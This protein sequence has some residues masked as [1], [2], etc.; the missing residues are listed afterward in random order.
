MAIEI[1]YNFKPRPYQLDLFQHMEAKLADPNTNEAKALLVWPRQIGKDTTCFAF[2]VRQAASVSGNYFYIFP[3]AKEA[4]KALWDKIMDD[5]SKLLDLLPEQVIARKS[6]QEMFIELSFPILGVNSTIQIIG[7]DLN[8]DAIRGITPQGVVFSEFAFSDFA[9]YK[10]LLAALRRKGCWHIINSTPNG[11]NHFYNIFQGA[12]QSD[13]WYVSFKQGLWKDKDNYV[14]IKPY[15]YFE[16]QV[17]EGLT[18]WEDLEREIGCSFSTGMKGAFYVDQIEEAYNSKR[19]GEFS[20]DDTLKVDTFWDLGVDDSTAVFFRQKINNKIVFIDYYEDSGKDLQHYV[21]VLE[22]KNYNYGTH[23]LPHDANHR[24]L[25]TGNTT[26][27][28]FGDLLKDARISDDIWVLERLPVQ[29]GINAVR[30]RFSR[31]HF[32]NEKCIDALKKLELYHRRYDK[33]RETF[34][35]EPVHD[36]TSHTADALRMEAMSEDIRQDNFYKQNKIQIISEYDI[37]D[38]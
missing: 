14:F 20:Y 38:T 2:M 26:A 3:T 10:N 24:S 35:S 15:E 28:M 4:K 27:R 6:N 17:K 32:D 9:V 37:F 8:P 31:Y 23:Y 29:D 11:R 13:G 12:S 33:K 30:S 16:Q 1:P 25:Q 19:I 22:S 21:K 34:I 18:T 36:Y 7:L 5:G